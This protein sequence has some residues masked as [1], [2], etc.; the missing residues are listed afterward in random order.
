MRK[1]TLSHIE[2]FKN[3]LIEEEKSKATIEKYERDLKAFYI[4]IGEQ[5]LNK[6]CVL[7][8][9]AYLCDNY[10]TASVNSMLS[11]I[12][13]FFSYLDIK[14]EIV[15]SIDF[16]FRVC[17]NIRANNFLIIFVAVKCTVR[18]IK[19]YFAYVEDIRTLRLTSEL[20]ELRVG[21]AKRIQELRY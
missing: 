11:S 4:W 21:Y 16:Y 19:S 3:Y 7:N 5:E 2:E 10:A 6:A 14:K 18:I 8:Y 9:K 13:S 12:N 1:I 17:Y 15:K 20:V